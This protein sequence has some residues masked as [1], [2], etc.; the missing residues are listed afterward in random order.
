[1]R[2][3]KPSIVSLGCASGVIQHVGDKTMH[4]V[5][6]AINPQDLKS[7]GGAYDMDE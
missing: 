2:Y 7:T 4:R 3:L 1:M 6:D 5:T